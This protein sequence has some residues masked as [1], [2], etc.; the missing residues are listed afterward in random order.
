MDCSPPGSSLRGIF[1]ERIP[2]WVAISQ[3]RGSSW[4]TDGTHV[5]YISRNGRWILYQLHDLGNPGTVINASKENKK[6]IVRMDHVWLCALITQITQIFSK[7]L[8]LWH[9]GALLTQERWPL[10]GLANSEIQRTVLLGVSL[11]YAN[12]P[13]QSPHMSSAKLLPIKSL[14]PVL[15]TPESCVRQVR[16]ATCLPCL[17]HSFPHENLN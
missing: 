16:A 4:P 15:I 7:F 1:Q 11:L 6:V 8:M 9:L 13:I 5:S 3:S 17:I 2:E 14:S 12:K 10:L